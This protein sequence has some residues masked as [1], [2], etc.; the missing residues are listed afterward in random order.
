MFSSI[1]GMVGTITLLALNLANEY[2][3]DSQHAQIEV[4][5]FAQ[6]LE[7]HASA[8][9]QKIDLMLR[10]VQRSVQPGDMQPGRTAG[11]ARKQT[12]HALLKSQVEYAPEVSVMHVADALGNYIYSSLDPIPAINIAD[13][14]YFKKQRNDASA[15]LVI[16]PPLVSRTTK[17]WTLV[18]SRRINFD[19]G[20]FAGIVNVILNLDYFQQFYRT[21]N[22]GTLGVVAMYDKEYHLAARYPPN[23]AMMGKAVPIGVKSYINRGEKFGVYHVKTPL[24]GVERQI[25]FRQVKDL[26]LFVFAG[27]GDDNYLARWHRHIWQYSIGV[28]IF[29]LVM[30]TFILRQ[31]RAEEAL[32]NSDIK[33]KSAEEE[34]KNLA[35]FDTLTRLPNRRLLQ[36]RIQQALASSERSGKIGALLFIDLDNFKT[37]NDTLGHDIGD[38]LL[39]QVAQRL[40]SCIR[41][42]DTVARLGGDEFVVMLEDLS[43]HNREAVNQTE[44]I[45]EKILIL[46][47]LPYQLASYE[48]H[49]TPSIGATLFK[50]REQGIEDLLKQADIAMYQAKKAGRNTLRFF[51]QLMQDTLTA[52]TS[53]ES[54]L[55][56]ALERL[57]F[58]LLYQVQVDHLNHPVGA[59]AL[60]RWLHPERGLVSPDQFIPLAEETGLILPIGQWVLETA[61]AQLVKWSAQPE[62]AHLTVAVNVSAYQFQQDNF[63]NNVLEILQRTGANPERLKLE[64]TESVLVSNIDSIV[65]KMRIL[66]NVGVGFSLD[67]FGTGYSSLSYLSRMPLDQLKIDRSFV[68]N[69]ESNDDAVAICAATIS[70]AHSLKLKVVAEGVETAAH[71]YIL[72]TVHRCDF[73]QG[74]LIGKPA[75]IEEFEKSLSMAKLN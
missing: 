49:S 26:P 43:E 44:A 40:E 5:N 57:Q 42:C 39:I 7:E 74:Y 18:L 55:R 17:Q 48:H 15:G 54:D 1:A 34:I 16:S 37:L 20:S 38:L 71:R 33:N 10:E 29:S 12:L 36:D 63:A 3:D 60:I 66:K 56:K 4:A 23:E 53:L 30:I 65:A 22:L 45:G 62:T 46:L 51:D 50:S 69:I 25:G 11:R 2:Q 31:R 52:R 41:K 67:D 73:L 58:C 24:D 9:V 21:L 27:I 13:R 64:L 14:D 47:N 59:E 28:L 68:K 35:Y 75:P 32:R 70:L 6:L 61:C 8:T 19:D 72:S